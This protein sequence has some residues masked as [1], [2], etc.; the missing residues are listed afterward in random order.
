MLRK[1]LEGILF[2]RSN[3]PEV[4][5]RQITQKYDYE[6]IDL[7]EPI[8]L[9]H[10]EDKNFYLFPPNLPI[11]LL[12]LYICSKP[13]LHVQL[14]SKNIY[15]IPVVEK[16]A[17]YILSEESPIKISFKTEEGKEI[18]FIEEEGELVIEFGI[19]YNNAYELKN[20]E[21]LKSLIKNACEKYS[22]KV[23]EIKEYLEEFL[24]AIKNEEEKSRTSYII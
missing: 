24:N 11:F 20:Y 9:L 18:L 13:P 15:L 12:S 21:I 17:Y 22:L 7:S 10:L 23:Y 8:I 2:P 19:I 3:F 16:A 1:E 6:E 14:N 4:Q 5:G